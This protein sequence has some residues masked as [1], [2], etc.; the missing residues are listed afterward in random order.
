MPISA[1]R[2]VNV[3]PALKSVTLCAGGLLLLLK[4]T[5]VPDQEVDRPAKSFAVFHELFFREWAFTG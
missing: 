4:L 2:N 5:G 3:A 1:L